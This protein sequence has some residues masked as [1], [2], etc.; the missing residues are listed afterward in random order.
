M[1][2]QTL[3][4]PSNQV[5]EL[6]ECDALLTGFAPGFDEES[7]QVSSSERTPP[8]PDVVNQSHQLILG[9]FHRPPLTPAIDLSTPS[10]P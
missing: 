2:E 1:R 8:R 7:S 4:P 9:L 6:C 5:R 3:P 10:R